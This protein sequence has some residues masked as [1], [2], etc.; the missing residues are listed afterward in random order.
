MLGHLSSLQVHHIFPKALLYKHSYARGEVNAVANFCFLTQQSNLTISDRQPDDY[1]TEVESNHPGVLASQWI[2]TDPD[3]WRVERYRDFLEA[4]RQLLARSANQLFED[5]R[6]A[7]LPARDPLERVVVTETPEVDEE[8]AA[9]RVLVEEFLAQGYAEPQLDAEISD[10]ESGDVLAVAEAFWDRGLQPGLGEP[11]VLELDP[12][13]SNVDRMRALGYEVFTSTGSLR[14]FAERRS[15]EAVGE[16]PPSDAGP[17]P[18]EVERDASDS[19]AQLE[20]DD[21]NRVFN[22]AMR[23]VYV[24]ARQEAGYQAT[25]FLEML[26]RHGALDT[27][28]RLLA[29]STTSD[30]FTAL[31]ERQRL[32]L[33]VENVVLRPEFE[34][35]FTD[36][37]RETA[38]RRL[39][40][41]GFTPDHQ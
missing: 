37:E 26:S 35:L 8:F 39:S 4:R 34:R 13:G 10:P 25:Y 33:T 21:V 29:S 11:V 15:R 23:D 3:L 14:E 1:F 30:G 16:D 18:Q 6:A 17:T 27:A 28:R 22:L 19:S 7:T 24:K 32:D 40:E 20:E 38:R 36:E 2:P 5:L 41:F 12:T 9:V 31:W